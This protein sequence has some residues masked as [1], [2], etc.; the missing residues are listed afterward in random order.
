MADTER[1]V[2][3][4]TGTDP[5][6]P[7]GPPEPPEARRT[8]ETRRTDEARR[9][10]GPAEAPAA[11]RTPEAPAARGTTEAAAGTP[12]PMEAP[13]RHRPTGQTGP[14][15]PATSATSA[16]STATAAPGAD[17]AGRAPDTAGPAA[18]FAHEESDKLTL[19]LRQAVAAFVDEPRGSVEEADQVLEEIAA[20]FTEAVARRRRTLRT[21]WQSPDKATGKSTGR[22]T[23]KQA[24]ARPAVGAD[25][26]QLRLA[27]RD[28][29]ELAERL[30]RV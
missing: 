16:G 20:R 12:W 1:P 28:Y 2:T 19:R 27:L 6:Q 18:L 5:R 7:S 30:L 29:R 23:D 22:S 17:T 25:T 9:R 13:E 21:S 8:G 26:E 3:D 11:P 24:E 15:E 4:A 14:V 10:G